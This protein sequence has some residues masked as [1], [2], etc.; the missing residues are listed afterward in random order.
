MRA[1]AVRPDQQKDIPMHIAGKFAIAAALLSGPLFLAA[2]QAPAAPA[3]GAVAAAGARSI[4]ARAP[5]IVMIKAKKDQDR[6]RDRH[7]KGKRA[8]HRHQRH[9]RR[10]E[11]RGDHDARND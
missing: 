1:L 2:P 10:H 4:P 6:D 7:H 3:A 11:K 9:D 8:P 5:D